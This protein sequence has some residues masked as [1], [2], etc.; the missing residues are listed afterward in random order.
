LGKLRRIHAMM[1]KLK[2]RFPV[3]L[4]AGAVIV[5]LCALYVQTH[6]SVFNESFWEHAHCIKGTGLSLLQYAADHGGKFP[7][8]TNGYGDALLLITNEMNNFWA[9]LTGPGYDGQVF[10]EAARTGRHI[11]E[12]ACG[13]VYVQGLSQAN[14][15]QIALLF[16]KLA[17]PGGDHCHLLARLRAPLVREV[18]TTG[19]G[20]KQIPETEWPAY[21]RHQIELLVAAGVAAKQAKSY[22]SKKPKS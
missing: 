2:R 8:H 14:D 11:P 17:T 6:P 3:L 7:S 16:D 21:S 18:W 13:R 19:A 10:A 15:P 22:Y 5:A 1:L 9:G 4:L 20:M 12:D